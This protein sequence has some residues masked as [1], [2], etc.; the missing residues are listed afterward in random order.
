VNYANER[1]YQGWNV[2]EFTV[3]LYSEVLRTLSLA[4]LG[5]R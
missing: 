4:P 3:L 1:T 5:M 2:R